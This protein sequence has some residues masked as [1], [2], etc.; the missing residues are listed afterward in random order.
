MKVALLTPVYWPEVRRGTERF[1]HELAGGLR[2]AGHAPR[3][4]TGH[5]GPPRTTV[6]DGVPI[7]RVP[8]LPE[9]RLERRM[10]EQHLTHV[11]FAYAALRRGPGDEI[12]HALHPVSALA[13]ARAGR[14]LVLS[15]MGIPHRETLAT[16]RLRPEIVRAALHAAGAVVAL[17]EAAARAFDRWLGVRPRVIAPPVDV[18][19]FTPDPAAR[20]D[21]PTILCAADATQ[22]RKRVALLAEAFALVR[23][24]RPGARLVLNRP[25]GAP[26]FAAEGV[27]WR[28]L[29]D[30]AA[31]A[32]ACREAH[33]AALPSV[34][35]AFGLVLAE[36]LACGTPVVGSDRDGI[37][38][39]LDGDARVGRLFAGDDPAV[40]A[41]ALLEALELTGDPATAGHCRA[42]AEAFSVERCVEAYIDVY[43]DVLAR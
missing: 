41:R 8:R 16:R 40:L 3:I 15:G 43:R 37:P 20:A 30:R 31:L 22:P 17:S 32:A 29:D 7:V 6:E 39:V 38:E 28:D 27:E 11:P 13:A 19:A 23:R 26:P 36:A 35:E 10:Y 4:V 14:P 1:A 2:A 42:R 5:A 25:R 33:V 9:R 18:H 21:A 34:A 24:E 12:A